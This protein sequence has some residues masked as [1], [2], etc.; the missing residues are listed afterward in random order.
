M[1]VSYTHGLHDL[2]NG[3]YAFLQPDGSW[4]MSNAG[5]VVGEIELPSEGTAFP[6][7]APSYGC[8]LAGS[9]LPVGGSNIP[10]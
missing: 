3:V 1:T 5:L 8:I 7:I 9:Q 6:R 2:G 4:G 10:A